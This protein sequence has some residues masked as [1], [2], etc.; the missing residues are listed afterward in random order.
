[1]IFHKIVDGIQPDGMVCLQGGLCNNSQITAAV[2]IQ[3]LHSVGRGIPVT[4]AVAACIIRGL[5]KIFRH[6]RVRNGIPPDRQIGMIFFAEIQKRNAGDN[7]H[8]DLTSVLKKI[9][10]T[11]IYVLHAGKQFRRHFKTQILRKHIKCPKAGRIQRIRQRICNKAH[12][13]HFIP[14]Y[15]HLFP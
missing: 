12:L 13:D 14:A 6:L 4:D 5:G 3:C 9:L 11:G 1:M 15:R 7:R 10:S 8:D 2:I